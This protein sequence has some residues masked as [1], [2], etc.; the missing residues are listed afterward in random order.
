MLTRVVSLVLYHSTLS[1]EPFA[2]GNLFT[3]CTNSIP[4]AGILTNGNL[5]GTIVNA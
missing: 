3:N 5:Y 1:L 4:M 2:N